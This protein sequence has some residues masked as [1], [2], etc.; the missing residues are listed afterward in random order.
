[1][2]NATDYIN[3][4]N[5]TID[6]YTTNISTGVINSPAAIFS[7]TNNPSSLRVSGDAE[8]DGDIT[9]KGV[10]LNDMLA[11]I[12]KRLAILVPDP[13]KLE[14]FEALQKAYQQYKTLEALCELSNKK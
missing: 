4:P 1:M 6:T 2:Y 11:D 8:F 3:L 5:S 7:T 14:H 10:K 9:I 12:Q 13:A